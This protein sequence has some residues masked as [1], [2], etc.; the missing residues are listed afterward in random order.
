[1]SRI[2]L[3]L[4]ALILVAG[5]VGFASPSAPDTEDGTLVV[6]AILVGADLS[7]TPVPKQGFSIVTEGAAPRSAMTNFQGE[8]RISLPAGSYRIRIDSPVEFEGR[9]YSWD[10]AFDIRAASETELDLSNDVATIETLGEPDGG[11]VDEGAL[12]RRYKSGVFKIISDGGHGSGFLIDEEGLILTNH[13]VIRDAEYLAAKVD[14][15][16]K[17]SVVLLAED[18]TN[19]LAVLRIHPDTVQGLPVL[20]LARD[21]VDE[22]ATAVGDDVLAIG[23]PLMTETILTSGMISKVEDTSIFSDI[24]INPGNSGGPAL[25]DSGEVV[26]INTFGLGGTSGPGL[27]GITRIYVAAAVIQDARDR[28]PSSTTP[29]LQALLMESSYRFP[30]DVVRDLAL[31]RR[32]RPK[33]YNIEA[34]KIDVQIFTPVLMASNVIRAER[35]ALEGRKKRRKKKDRTA[36]EDY[37]PGSRFYEWTKSA[38]N[39]RPV[40]RIRAYP[41]I[42]MKAGSAWKVALVGGRASYRFKTDFQRM[43]LLRNGEPVEPVHPGRIKEVVHVDA[44][45][46][47]KD[48]GYFGYYEYLPEAFEPGARLTL[49]IW[50]QDNPE[51][52]VREI[53]HEMMV[54]VWQDFAPYRESASPAVDEDPGEP[55][56]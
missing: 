35:E 45:A 47:M 16:H 29:S 49:R 32:P 31:A 2:S 53:T 5:S 34:G 18:S 50:E 4:L 56:R 27:S 1:M 55:Q 20:P 7:L 36:E 33:D 30:P 38:E 21:S 10:V 26:G 39:F 22:P 54:R 37:Q 41:E 40:V 14:E 6:R 3:L 44:G 46:V 25:N 15:E 13:H 42:K 51:P 12:Y 28:L 23:S 11:E 48:V 9:R 43:V 17:Y 8:I 52:T 19:D 24:N